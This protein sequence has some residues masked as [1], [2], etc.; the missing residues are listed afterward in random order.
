MTEQV[1]QCI[2]HQRKAARDTVTIININFDTSNSKL[3]EDDVVIPLHFQLYY[4]S[5]AALYTKNSTKSASAIT[6]VK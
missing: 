4:T 2:V 5:Y 1:Y 6:T 3:S